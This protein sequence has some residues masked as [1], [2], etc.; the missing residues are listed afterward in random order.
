[1]KKILTIFIMVLSLSCVFLLASCDKKIDV[2]NVTFSDATYDYD[3]TAKKIEVQNLPDGVEV[4]YDPSN[5]QTEA[6]VYRITATIM[7][8]EGNVLIELTAVLTIEADEE[9]D[10]ITGGETG[11]EEET[12][13]EHTCSFDGEWKKDETNHWH[14]CSCGEIDTPAPLP[15]PKA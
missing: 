10:S 4:E 7:D 11:G 2:S 12:L 3:G 13:P 1:M 15:P 5:S 14:E 8:E 9:T 6:G